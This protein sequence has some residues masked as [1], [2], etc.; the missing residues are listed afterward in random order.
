[1]ATSTYTC[2]RAMDAP[3][4][5]SSIPFYVHLHFFSKNVCTVYMIYIIVW[6]HIDVYLYFFLNNAYTDLILN[7]FSPSNFRGRRRRSA[8]NNRLETLQRIVRILANNPDMFVAEEKILPLP[9]V[10]FKIFLF[11]RNDQRL[12]ILRE[13][14]PKSTFEIR[15]TKIKFTYSFF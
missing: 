3:I 11:F 9:L 4:R 5:S 6:Y 7:Q 13:L 14:S 10:S 1:M 12:S 2:F 15:E 8:T